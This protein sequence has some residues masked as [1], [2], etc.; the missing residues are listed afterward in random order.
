MTNRERLISYLPEAD[1]EAFAAHLAAVS[2]E[3]VD[4]LFEE[5]N[6]HTNTTGIGPVGPPVGIPIRPDAVRAV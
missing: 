3:D 5:L 1:R 4:T 2:D 6:R